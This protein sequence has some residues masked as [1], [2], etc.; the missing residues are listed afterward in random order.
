MSIA[1]LER[2]ARAL[3]E[4]VGDVV[5]V[6]GATIG[7]WLTDP[8]APAP[9][10]T[11]DVDVIVE[12]ASRGRFAQF[13]KRLREHG[14]S[15]DRESGLICRWLQGGD[16][17]L[18]AMPT[19][20][21]ILGFANRWQAAAV[22]HARTRALPSGAQIAAVSAPFLLGTKPDAGE[23]TTSAAATSPTSSA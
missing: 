16:V 14:F 11:K 6:G 3:G 10:P 13:E 7:L 12:V 19:D 18:D 15:E 20:A 1:L 8:A 2:A 9:R 4:L 17:I 22:P 21:S 5:F 23:M